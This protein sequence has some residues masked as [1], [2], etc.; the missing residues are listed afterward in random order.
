MRIVH[1]LLW[2]PALL[3]AQ[4]MYHEVPL[5]LSEALQD[6]EM[7]SGLLRLVDKTHPLPADYVPDTLV[8]L[9]QYQDVLILNKLGMEV[10][11]RM[12]PDLIAMT[13]AAKAQGVLLDISSAYRSFSYQKKLYERAVASLGKER[14]SREV[15]LPGS[16]QH[17]LGT[18]L[19]FG[20]I[21]PEFADT[22]AGKWL[23]DHAQEFGFSLSYP[24][25]VQEQ[26]GYVFES[27]HY[28]YL[29][30]PVTAIIRQYFHG[31][32]V[33]FLNFWDEHQ[34]K[35]SHIIREHTYEG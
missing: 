23:A 34:K 31:L 9:D 24:D 5:S 10:D 17:Q 21:T 29:G 1:Y 30:R 19:D 11:S 25:G 32:Q 4:N 26:T 13:K 27:W 20:S 33:Q 18:A 15:A 6:L 7:S 14:A 16:S 28:R 2:A 22:P 12:I 3:Y 8:S 35:H